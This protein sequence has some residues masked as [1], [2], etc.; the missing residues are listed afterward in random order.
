MRRIALSFAIVA[1]VL[2]LAGI[3]VPEDKKK[4]PTPADTL[5]G[6]TWLAGSWE[7]QMWGGTFRAYYSTPEGG[8]I[9]SHSQLIKE[10]KPVFYE[11]EV[12]EVDGKVLRYQPYPGGKK[13]GGFV[14]TS[15]SFAL[16]LHPAPGADRV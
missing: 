16:G 7:G 12:F 5:A 9:L 6:M 10:G 13:A 14:L 15:S 1:T 8:K 3:A 2:V 4:E 11:F